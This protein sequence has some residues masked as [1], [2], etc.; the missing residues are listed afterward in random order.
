MKIRNILLLFT[1]FFIVGCSSEFEKIRT[2]NSP[3][4][5]LKNAYR[6]FQD[7]DYYRAQSLFEESIQYY[8]GQKEAE[9]IYYN[10]AYTHY[11]LGEFVLASYYFDNFS[12]TFY[13]SDKKDEAEFMSAYSNY[14]MSPNYKLDQSYT[15]KA[16]EGFQTFINTHPQSERVVE[17]NELIDE[18]REKLERKSFE[19]GLLYNRIGQYQAALAS[20]DNMLKD[21]PETKRAEEARF[22]MLKSEYILAEKSIYEKKE[23]R[24]L[25]ATKLYDTFIK[26]HPKSKFK[27]EALE[28][29]KNSQIQIEKYRV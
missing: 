19:Q 4:L 10:L 20:F 18:M 16:I 5:I 27:K 12:K 8:R 9:E 17:C 25:E 13:N 1:V 21:F 6:Y 28:I 22:M 29:L 11:H 3:E 26:K 15:K 23:E 2:S 24:F 7:E 14:R